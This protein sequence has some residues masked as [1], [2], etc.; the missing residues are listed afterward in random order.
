LAFIG[1]SIEFTQVGK[2]GNGSSDEEVNRKIRQSTYVR[3]LERI[4]IEEPCVFHFEDGIR[5]RF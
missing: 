1:R 3:Y 5:L 4:R 2:N